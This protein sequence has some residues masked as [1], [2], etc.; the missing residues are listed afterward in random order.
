MDSE[1][2]HVGSD[3][4]LFIDHRFIDSAE[5]VALRV[6]PPRKEST[7]LFPRDKPWEAFT[8]GWHSIDWDPETRR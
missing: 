8:I 2:I 3:K 5:Q 1:P 6:N 7:D 4:Q